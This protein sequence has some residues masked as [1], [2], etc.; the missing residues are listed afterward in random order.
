MNKVRHDKAWYQ[1][2][3]NQIPD[4]KETSN[5]VCSLCLSVLA[6]LSCTGVLFFFLST[7]QSVRRTTY[8]ALILFLLSK[9]VITP[10]GFYAVVDS[11]VR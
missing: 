1:I 6:C 7:F 2:K 8:L 3:P 10:A 4:K 9:T 11:S 5:Y